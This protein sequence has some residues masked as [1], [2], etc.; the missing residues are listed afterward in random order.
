LL[1]PALITTTRR[2][3][4]SFGDFAPNEGPYERQHVGSNDLPS[5]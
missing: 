3:R 5:A 2:H 1:A 4:G